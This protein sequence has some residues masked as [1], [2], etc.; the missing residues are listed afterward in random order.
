MLTPATLPTPLEHIQWLVR[1]GQ[2]V[3]TSCG[4]SIEVW[5]LKHD[6]SDSSTMSAWA[7]HFRSNYCS[8]DEMDLLIEDTGQSRKDFLL[9]HILPGN[10]KPGPSIRSGDFSEILLSDYLEYI[11]GYWVP[12]T[13][14]DSKTVKNESTKGSDVIGYHIVDPSSVSPEDTLI[15]IESKSQFSGDK[16][17]SRLQDAVNDSIKDYSRIGES[18]NATK[19]RLIQKQKFNDAKKVGRFQNIADKPF[20]QIFG[21]AALFTTATFGDTVIATTD[22]STHPYKDNLHLIVIHGNEMMNLVHKLYQLAAD[23]A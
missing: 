18:L 2:A 19:R 12:R 16:P 10:L 11:L 8:D 7:K 4:R 1:T 23:E 5:E 13:R 14:F 6:E 9:N 21:A 15:I 22:I 3:K 20:N 17:T